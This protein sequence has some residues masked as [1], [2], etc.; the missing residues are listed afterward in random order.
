[1]TKY[2]KAFARCRNCVKLEKCA[3]ALEG[4]IWVTHIPIPEDINC[5]HF[6]ELG[7]AMKEYVQDKIH[8]LYMKEMNKENYNV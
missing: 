1:M 6:H 2:E 7:E 5:E 8:E 4:F 3:D